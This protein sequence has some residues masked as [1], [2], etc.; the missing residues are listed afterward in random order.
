MLETVGAELVFRK[1]PLPF[2][3]L[4]SRISCNCNLAQIFSYQ[5][6]VCYLSCVHGF[7]V[8]SFN[9]NYLT[10]ISIT[11]PRVFATFRRK[12]YTHCLDSRML[13]H[14]K[15]GVAD[16]N[17]TRKTEGLSPICMPIPSQQHISLAAS[18]TLTA[19]L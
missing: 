7:C 10:L 18:C 17:R 11:L 2:L 19:K 13:S 3:Q 14:P 9:T 1:Q 12:N 8:Y 6:A 4:A 16:G 15:N 5:L